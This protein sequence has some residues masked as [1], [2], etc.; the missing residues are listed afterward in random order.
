MRTYD[1]GEVWLLLRSIADQ[2]LVLDTFDYHHATQSRVD[3]P[4]QWPRSLS[5]RK[6]GEGEGKEE[7]EAAVEEA[8]W[9]GWEGVE[10]VA[11]VLQKR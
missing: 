4:L 9:V 11:V 10:A 2:F 8:E 6:S 3:C 7:V 5:E 1:R